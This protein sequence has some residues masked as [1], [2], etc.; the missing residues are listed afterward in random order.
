LT[1]LWTAILRVF[2]SNDILHHFSTKGL[3]PLIVLQ[4]VLL[5]ALG[6]YNVI[7]WLQSRKLRRIQTLYPMENKLWCFRRAVLGSHKVFPTKT[8]VQMTYTTGTVS[9]NNDYSFSPRR[10]CRF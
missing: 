5:P 6:L 9:M 1:Y 8:A 10:N 2:E 4:L 7:T 3:Y